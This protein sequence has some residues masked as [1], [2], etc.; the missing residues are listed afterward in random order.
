MMRVI[1]QKTVFQ[2][3]LFHVEELTFEENGKTSFH[4]NV[5]RHS[6]VSVFPL[7]DSYEIYLISQYRSLY[8][9]ILYEATAGFVNDKE[10]PLSAAK[11]E[12]KEETGIIAKRWIKLADVHTAA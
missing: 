11:R 8:A 1:S 9:S 2:A 7:T 5:I 6:T 4:H 3:K 12:L 10:D